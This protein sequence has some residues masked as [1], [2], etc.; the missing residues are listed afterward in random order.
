MASTLTVSQLN[1]YVA[2]KIRGDLRLKSIAV[3]GE[4]SNLVAHYRS[5]HLYFTLKDADAAVKA[6]MFASAAQRLK[7]MPDNGLRVV[8][9]CSVDLYEKDGSYQLVCTELLPVGAGEAAVGLEQLKEKLRKQGIF[10][11]SR[12][13]PLVPLPKRIAVVTSAGALR[14]RIF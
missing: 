2:S 7:F 1:R 14:C 6:V 3:T 11:E 4:I 13:K 8:A 12:K 9:V 10:D 5:G